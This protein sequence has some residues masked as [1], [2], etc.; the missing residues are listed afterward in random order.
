[1]PPAISNT[2]AM[3][4]TNCYAALKTGVKLFESSFA[5]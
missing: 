2:Y 3:G 1:M 4:L 5:G